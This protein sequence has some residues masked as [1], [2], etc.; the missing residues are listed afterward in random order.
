MRV[1]VVGGAGYIGSH[2]VR[3]LTRAG[4]EP[5]IFDSLVE[6]HRDVAE[7]LGVPLVEG[8]ILDRRALDAVFAGRV[9][10]GGQASKPA[11][12]EERTAL[13][14]PIRFE[15][16]TEERG[17]HAPRADRRLDGQA[18][19]PAP[20]EERTALAAA[21]PADGGF[22]AV[23]HFAAF[24]YVGESV[25][26]PGKYYRNNLAGSIELLE[27]ARAAGV[28]RFI[29]SSTCAVYGSPHAPDGLDESLVPDPINPYG[30][31]KLMFER[32]L[33]DADHAYGMK[34]T[35]LRYF[36][37]AGAASDGLLGE[38]HRIETHLIPLCLL[39]ALGKRPALTVFGTDYPT[40]DGTCIRDYIHVEDLATAHVLALDR[41]AAGAPSLIANVGTGR[42]HSVREVI[43]CVEQVT[44]RK[45][46][47]VDGP[48]RAGDPPFLYARNGLIRRELGW[49][50]KQP[51]LESM[52]RSAWGWFSKH[53]G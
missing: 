39:A 18:S 23:I 32:V 50:P 4:H 41:L 48:R 2:T 28:R 20:L 31:S 33:A 7:A 9:H 17:P 14:E 44:G 19:K 29:L 51:E 34:F 26:D 10:Q 12:P 38:R 49:E 24:A 35:A 11:P 15:V 27:A 5:V 46:P 6:G 40:P 8:D 47:F 30:R 13:A 43:A 52:V 21:A 42:G 1:L 36:N 25:T 16:E 37:A 53:A 45:V 22:D 3:E